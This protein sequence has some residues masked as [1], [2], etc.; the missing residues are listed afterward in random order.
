MQVGGVMKVHCSQLYHAPVSYI[1]GSYHHNALKIN[2]TE[3]PPHPVT[4]HTK[5][6]HVD[7]SSTPFHNHVHECDVYI[8]ACSDVWNPSH[9]LSGTR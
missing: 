2:T 9:L 1:G 7:H 6:M 5:L 3:V 4:H 8:S